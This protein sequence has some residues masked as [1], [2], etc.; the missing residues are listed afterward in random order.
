[1]SSYN[2]FLT[3]ISVAVKLCKLRQWVHEVV[4]SAAPGSLQTS[5]QDPLSNPIWIFFTM[6]NHSVF[7]KYIHEK[8]NTHLNCVSKNKADAFRSI[9]SHTVTC[10]ILQPLLSSAS[11]C[12]N[13]SHQCH[14]FSTG[15]LRRDYL[16]D[17]QAEPAGWFRRVVEDD[18]SLVLLL[19]I[20][21]QYVRTQ[22]W[23]WRCGLI[24]ICYSLGQ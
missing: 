19:P 23:L 7:P 1:M 14:Q 15:C 12:Q 18:F 6:M 9:V 20:L 8:I 17:K 16:V 2:V 13:S 22:C 3:C 5:V 24:Q 11:C 21:R 4:P 10:S